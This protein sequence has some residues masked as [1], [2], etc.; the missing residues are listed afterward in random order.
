M[1]RLLPFA[2]LLAAVPAFAADD[3]LPTLPPTPRTVPVPPIP[4]AE[5][6]LPED[7]RLQRRLDRLV[8]DRDQVIGVLHQAGE[9]VPVP[10][11]DP[12]DPAVAKPL[13]EHAAARRE[14]RQA[15]VDYIERTPKEKID[16]LDRGARRAQLALAGPLVAANYLAVAECWKDLASAPSG[17]RQQIAEGLA[18]LDSVDPTKLPDGDRPRALYLRLWFLCEDI[19]KAA[20]AGEARTQAIAKA[21]T[22]QAELTGTFPVSELALTS[23]SLFAALDLP[24]PPPEAVGDA[25]A[26]TTTAP[27]PAAA[28]APADAHGTPAPAHEAPAHGGH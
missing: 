7:E 6:G 18:S 5:V 1:R 8:R 26:P 10:T 24:A 14:L 9:A 15:L 4:D 23:E 17:T 2:L 22:V 19:R 13:K 21:R 27:A 20:L 12:A 28:H 16:P 11:P 3:G 25:P